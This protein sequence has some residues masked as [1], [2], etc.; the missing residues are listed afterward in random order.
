MTE[1][2]GLLAYVAVTW[3]ALQ[4]YDYRRHQSRCA[5]YRA[6]AQRLRHMRGAAR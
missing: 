3:V 1:F 6:R 2:A 4:L 5:A